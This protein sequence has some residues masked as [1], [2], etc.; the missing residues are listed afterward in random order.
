M[1]AARPFT[2]VYRSL[3]S[4]P[5]HLLPG[6][7][8]YHQL[9][10]LNWLLE[11]LTLER[12]G[13]FEPVT[14]CWDA[15]DPGRSRTTIKRLNKEKAIEAKWEQFIAPPKARHLTSKPFRVSSG[16][17]LT[18]KTSTLSVL[19]SSV[20]GSSVGSLLSL[21]TAPEHTCDEPVYTKG[22]RTLSAQESDSD[23]SSSEY[24]QK[25]LQ[26]LYLRVFKT[27]CNS[28]NQLTSA[29]DSNTVKVH[30]ESKQSTDGEKTESQKVKS[31]PMRR[32]SATTQLIHEKKA[33]LDGITASFVDKAEEL[34]LN[35][36]DA[37]DHCAKKRWD[38][39]VQRYRSLC[40]MVSGKRIPSAVTSITS[41]ASPRVQDSKIP[42]ST[43]D[44]Y[45]TQW[46]SALLSDLAPI[47]HSDR[48]VP[49]LLEKLSRFTECHTLRLHPR[50]F[51]KILNSLQL[52]ELCCPDL[53]VAIEI[54]RQNVVKMPKAEYDS[55][56]HNRVSQSQTTKSTT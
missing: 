44:P 12:S 28:D 13:R 31:S 52:W 32:T 7:Y 27:C 8:V 17:H 45:S 56:L 16:S 53:C 18:W 15:K 48:R 30:P 29:P 36:S 14:S 23:S 21:A 2:P 22:I 42:D 4:T 37:L 34:T 55:W 46:L 9:C 50:N 5:P 54:V 47:K 6:K 41:M 10:C 51:L 19:S 33:M 49:H 38:F 1:R 20:T 40:K 43:E 3:I 11:A 25:F 26:E 24:L 39:G 35:L